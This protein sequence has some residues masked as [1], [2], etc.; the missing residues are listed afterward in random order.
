MPYLRT[1]LGALALL[2]ALAGEA[3]AAGPADP[4]L[5]FVPPVEYTAERQSDTGAQC[6][7]LHRVRSTR[8]LAGEGIVY[9]MSGR[10]LLINRVRGGAG[11]LSRNQ[12]L[13]TRTSGALLCAGDIVQLAD[14]SP[15]FAAGFV[16]LGRF[17]RYH[18]P[19]RP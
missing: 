17:E 6:I 1:R 14:S 7:A 10:K 19:A 13:I 2:L 5:W 8:I 9:H 18:P 16:A 3:Q 11:L 4:G 12:I 15:G